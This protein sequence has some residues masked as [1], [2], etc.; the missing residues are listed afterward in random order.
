MSRHSGPDN[1]NPHHWREEDLERELEECEKKIDEMNEEILRLRISTRSRLNDEIARVENRR[2][3]VDA[4]NE[5]NRLGIALMEHRSRHG[6]RHPQTSR[7]PLPNLLSDEQIQMREEA[8]RASQRGER[9]PGGSARRNSRRHSLRTSPV[10][11]TPQSTMRFATIGGR[12]PPPAIGGGG[13]FTTPPRSGSNRSTNQE[14]PN[15]RTSPIQTP[16]RPQGSHGGRRYQNRRAL[17]LHNRISP[18]TSDDEGLVSSPGGDGMDGRRPGRRQTRSADG[19]RRRRGD[20]RTEK[21][22]PTLKF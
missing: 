22:K 18:P 6:S 1:E 7:R 4:K 8:R 19:A 9:A 10:N 17:L 5:R 20:S 16:N 13:A 12:T 11:T 14:Q 15:T 2:E 21:F 3:Y